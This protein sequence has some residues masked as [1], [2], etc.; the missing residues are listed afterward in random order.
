[1][2]DVWLACISFI[3]LIWF[4]LGSGFWISFFWVVYGV[5]CGLVRFDWVRDRFGF[6]LCGL[7]LCLFRF[8]LFG[9]ISFGISCFQG[10]GLDCCWFGVDC[11]VAGF[12]CDWIRSLA[13]LVVTGLGL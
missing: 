7:G 10:F 8:Y 11:V 9:R 12:G 13:G 6:G 3:G 1:V 2:I 4:R 5:H